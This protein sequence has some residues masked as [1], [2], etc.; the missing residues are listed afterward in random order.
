MLRLSSFLFHFLLRL[1]R[2]QRW[3]NNLSREFSLLGAPASDEKL[4]R[5]LKGRVKIPLWRHVKK[6]FFK[7]GWVRKARTLA[8]RFRLRAVKPVKPA[9]K[10]II[11]LTDVPASVE[12]A[13]RCIESA[14]R[15][16]EDDGLEI[17]AG[18]GRREVRDFFIRHGLTQGRLLRPV[19]LSAA[20]G[21]FA[22]HYKLWLRCLELGEPIIVLE[23]DAV[24][25]TFIPPLRFKHV[26]T[27]SVNEV[28]LRPTLRFI[29]ALRKFEG[30][31]VLHLWPYIPGT[32]CYAIKPEGARKLVEAAS[33]Q[34]VPAVDCFMSRENVD[35]V[36]YHPSPVVPDER[37]STIET[38]DSPQEPV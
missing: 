21:C 3:R 13:R 27:L 7:T 25:R 18:V 10:Y 2:V 6:F 17:F 38:S 35:L 8:V 14:K 22:S 11:T 32:A 34:F 36:Y 23:H 16:G 28:F 33:R 20:A 19:N 29:H 37:F 1:H 5:E 15:H 12:A 31:E 4:W 26:I 24:F 30:K 9:K